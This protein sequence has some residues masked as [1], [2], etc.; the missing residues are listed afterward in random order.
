MEIKISEMMAREMPLTPE[1][2]KFVD[3]MIPIQSFQK[4]EILLEEGQ[5]ARDCYFTIEGCV[6]SYQLIDGDERTTHFYVE[7]DPI[8][9]MTS[10]LN[11]TPANHYL[12]CVED[13]VLAVLHYDNELK[14]YKK[15]PRLEALCRT[16]IEQEFGKQQEILQHYLTKNPE[17]RY[18]MLL[19]TRPELLQRIPQYHLASFLGVQPESLSRIRK[20]IAQKDIP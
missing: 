12:A 2:A 3:E 20:R 9:S 11:K 6:R 18:L 19:K 14:L 16:N 17:E 10:Y 5:I 13:S 15:L 4:G 7:G 8:A 1:E